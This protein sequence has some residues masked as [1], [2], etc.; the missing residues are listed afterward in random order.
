MN[1]S[2]AKSRILTYSPVL[3]AF[4]IFFSLI[5]FKP[6]YGPMD[7]GRY[8]KLAKSVNDLPDFVK[9]VY[10]VG[11]VQDINDGFIRFTHIALVLPLY[12]FETPETL[13]IFNSIFVLLTACFLIKEIT[14]ILCKEFRVDFFVL[15]FISFLIWP[16]TFD[17]FIYPSLQEKSV[18]LLL[19]LNLRFIRYQEQ[20]NNP[21]LWD[22]IISF[23]L[24]FFAFGT[25]I[26]FVAL[27]PGLILYIN[28]SFVTTKMK[29]YRIFYT[30]SCSILSFILIFIAMKG[31]YTS[32]HSSSR[33]LLNFTN[34]FYNIWILCALI[35][36]FCSLVV[37]NLYESKNGALV[38][39]LFG[40]FICF[41]IMFWGSYSYI[42]SILGI[43]LSC[44]F[45]NL[46]TSLIKKFKFNI[47]QSQTIKWCVIFIS[48]IIS[49][50]WINYRSYTA[51]TNLRSIYVFL[52]SSYFKNIPNNSVFLPCNEAR[53]HY[54]FYSYI[55]ANRIPF[56]SLQST[57]S[58]I[59]TNRRLCP[60]NT[61]GRFL[62]PKH[63]SAESWNL[64][65]LS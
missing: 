54:N 62:W 42:L 59:F 11:L 46:F 25:K 64:F 52:E 58:Y 63:N 39:L 47:I 9:V 29:L 17:L 37:I 35:I 1:V 21:K 38:V 56:S 36:L 10:E 4:N 41:G 61:T 43:F 22:F 7:D 19:F 12:L 53:D 65:Q 16:W 6:Y 18:L 51:F 33:L 15:S 57:S 49:T 3:L 28:K 48:L 13:F 45:T 27:I 2:L 31:N 5:Y 14:I 20:K 44:L 23:T 34:S 8:L 40:A 30:I 32:S 26:H 24:L 60:Y 55:L 50:L